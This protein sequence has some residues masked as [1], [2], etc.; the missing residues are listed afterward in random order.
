MWA[1]FKQQALQAR[2]YENPSF[3]SHDGRSPFPSHQPPNPNVE[4]MQTFQKLKKPE[5]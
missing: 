4:S 2:A 3:C 1:A 5:T